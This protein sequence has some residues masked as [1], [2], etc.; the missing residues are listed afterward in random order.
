MLRYLWQLHRF[1]FLCLY[2]LKRYAE[3]R[4]YVSANKPHFSVVISHQTAVSC[5]QCRAEKIRCRRGQKVRGVGAVLHR[6]GISI[7]AWPWAVNSMVM[8]AAL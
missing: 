1:S 5:T 3:G 2:K 8:M 4:V 6:R 7:A